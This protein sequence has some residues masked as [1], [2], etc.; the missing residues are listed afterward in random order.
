M[1]KHRRLYLT[2]NPS[3]LRNYYLTSPGVDTCTIAEHCRLQGQRS[4]SP[5]KARQN[6]HQTKPSSALPSMHVRAVSRRAFI[7]PPARTTGR[8]KPNRTKSPLGRSAHLTHRTPVERAV[9]MVHPPPPCRIVAP[10][11]RTPI[12]PTL[13]AS[14]RVRVSRR[15]YMCDIDS[16]PHH[17]QPTHLPTHTRGDRHGPR[18][19]A[20]DRIHLTA[21]P[22]LPTAQLGADAPRYHVVEMMLASPPLPHC[23]T[24]RRLICSSL[25]SSD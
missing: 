4:S 19:G 12:I 9:G 10:A 11:A 13:Y 7:S 17:H 15:L 24:S 2:S 14:L 23:Y 8:G 25:S 21:L 1:S 22:P 3:L 5:P 18:R 16:S 20:A 6:H